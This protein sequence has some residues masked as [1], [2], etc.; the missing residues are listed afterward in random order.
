MTVRIGL[1]CVLAQW[2]KHPLP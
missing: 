1:W 2:R